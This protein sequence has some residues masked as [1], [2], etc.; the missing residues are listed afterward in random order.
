MGSREVQVGSEKGG[1][2]PCGLPGSPRASGSGPLGA[3]WGGP[4]FARGGQGFNF[5]DKTGVI[6]TI[7]FF[8]L[9]DFW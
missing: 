8:D 4:G 5:D 1:R 3:F 6:L 9:S 2:R 7:L